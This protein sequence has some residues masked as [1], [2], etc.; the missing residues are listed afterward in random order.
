VLDVF[1]MGF[2]QRALAAGVIISLLL[3]MLS[4]FVVLRRLSFVGVGIS[5]AAFGG[6]ALGFWLG[7]DPTFTG[8]LFAM[9]VGFLIGWASRSGR[10][11]ADTAIGIFFAA[12]MA[13]GAVFLAL[14]RKYNADV[15]GTLFGD[16]ST[17]WP[18]D[19]WLIV[20]VG[21]A[22]ALFL[23]VFFKELIY[24]SFDPEMARVSGVP[25][26][27][28]EYLLLAALALTVVI[29]VK[30]VGIVLLAALLVA[31]AACALLWS[32]TISGVV[33]LSLAVALGATLGG[34]VISVYVNLPSG[35]TIVCLITV[36]F[37]VSLGT[38]RLRGI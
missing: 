24:I 27:A 11:K 7:V 29:G 21:L 8:V 19:L 37:L 26:T 2:M 3:G 17:I 31:P 25:V 18:G 36:I 22:V 6:I 12:A 34:L 9:G 32:R 15:M 4:V 16:I 10:I 13:L 30:V 5:H 33:M 14:S 28:L 23:A 38:A 20:G 35:A 1:T